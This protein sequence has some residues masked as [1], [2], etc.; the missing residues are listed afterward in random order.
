M[1]CYL[2]SK[3]DFGHEHI[4]ES[5]QC[6]FIFYWVILFEGLVEIWESSLEI[7]FLWCME[8]A[9]LE[10]IK[11]WKSITLLKHPI[12]KGF[13]LISLKFISLTKNLFQSNSCKNRML[14]HLNQEVIYHF[15]SNQVFNLLFRQISL[16]FLWATYIKKRFFRKAL[17]RWYEL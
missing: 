10:N 8:Y 14:T 1:Y 7:T 17:D 5:S 13:S 3:H 16:Q 12:I 2:R 15:L 4:L 9:R 6:H 11:I